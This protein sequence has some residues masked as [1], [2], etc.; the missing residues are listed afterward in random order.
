MIS[1]LK[2]WSQFGR[3][4][5]NG[6]GVKSSRGDYDLIVG[7]LKNRF[8]PVENELFV[9]ILASILPETKQRVNPSK[10]GGFLVECDGLKR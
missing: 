7:V 3:G 9:F 1:M 8:E 5:R 10:R 6:F 2:E 4:E